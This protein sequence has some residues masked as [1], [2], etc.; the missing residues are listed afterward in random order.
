MKVLFL[1]I[2]IANALLALTIKHPIAQYKV[3]GAVTDIVYENNKLYCATSASSVDI[4]DIKTKKTVQKIT[5]PHI[6]DFMGNDIE[7]KIYSV[8]V[9]HDKILLLSQANHG[10]RQIDILSDK[11]LTRVLD[12]SQKLYI[13]K[14]KF[15]ND[16]TIILALLSNDIISYNIH[17]KKNNWILQAS[18]SKFSNFVLSEDKTEVIVSDESG[19]L[20]IFDTNDGTLLKTLSGQNLDNVFQVDYKN[21]VIATAGQDRR[22]VVYDAK[23]NSSYYKLSKFLIY[24]VGV[25]PSGKLIAYSSDENNNIT[26]FDANA[27]RTLAIYGDNKM[28]PVKILFISKK[29]FFVAT[30]DTVINLYEID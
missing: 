26:V 14:A 17:T 20:H 22:V 27:K 8:D 19:D 7:A 29:Q 1:S 10:F 21:G 11:K 28:I 3:D 4:V 9:L 2:F 6:K 18:Q 15:V 13:A 5:V 24:S 16:S 12:A 30:D 25:S 23:T